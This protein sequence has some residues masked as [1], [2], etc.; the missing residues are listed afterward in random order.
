MVVQF[1]MEKEQEE[2]QLPNL[3]N[4][5]VRSCKT[6]VGSKRPKMCDTPHC[7]TIGDLPRNESEVSVSKSFCVNKVEQKDSSQGQGVPVDSAQPNQWAFPVKPEPIMRWRAAAKIKAHLKKWR[8]KVSSQT[9][10]LAEVAEL[11]EP[12]AP[13]RNQLWLEEPELP[14]QED[15]E[16]LTE[17]EALLRGHHDNLEAA[18]KFII[19]CVKNP[20]K[21]TTGF[22][23]R[24][25]KIALSLKCS[26]EAIRSGAQKIENERLESFGNMFESLLSLLRKQGADEVPRSEFLRFPELLQREKDLQSHLRSSNHR[27]KLQI[28][29][30]LQQGFTGPLQS[31]DEALELLEKAIVALDLSPGRTANVLCGIAGSATTPSDAL[32]SGI[33]TI[34]RVVNQFV[35]PNTS[36]KF[37]VLVAGWTLCS[38]LTK[39]VVSLEAQSDRS[40]SV[41]SC[42]QKSATKLAAKFTRKYQTKMQVAPS[43]SSKQDEMNATFWQALP[44]GELLWNLGYGAEVLDDM[45]FKSLLCTSW[46]LFDSFDSAGYLLGPVGLGR[47]RPRLDS[48]AELDLDPDL[49]SRDPEHACVQLGKAGVL[50]Q[51]ITVMIEGDPRLA[52]IAALFGT[53]YV[54]N[55]IR[56]TANSFVNLVEGAAGSA[57]AQVNRSALALAD[58]LSNDVEELM[59]GRQVHVCL[60]NGQYTITPVSS[61]KNPLASWHHNVTAQVMEHAKVKAAGSSEEVKE[62]RPMEKFLLGYNNLL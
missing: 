51:Q 39:Q 23:K 47:L 29:S 22:T 33:G 55:R 52:R 37:D 16:A 4:R 32:A 54:A 31:S 20:T 21:G 36:T 48:L 42:Q 26:K 46:S 15:L 19:T 28:D 61:N 43:S 14:T 8:S 60:A 24:E 40:S 25:L 30:M 45:D 27:E 1:S 7:N 9:R 62:L 35:A 5:H 58:L 10:Q 11:Q 12:A 2:E 34:M 38:A 56:S 6:M 57:A 17:L 3:L 53:S 13:A 41:Q 59:G 50:L 44:P 18:Y 49:L